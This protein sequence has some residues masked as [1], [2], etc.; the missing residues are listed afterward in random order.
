MATYNNSLNSAQ[1]W[2]E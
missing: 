1:N 2:T